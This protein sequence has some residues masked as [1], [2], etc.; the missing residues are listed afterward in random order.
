M[1]SETRRVAVTGLG[2]ISS[3]G[4]SYEQVTDALRSGASGIEAVPDWADFG[5]KSLVAGTITD[6]EE[7]I[8]ASGISRTSQRGM[9]QAALF[10]C[11]CAQ[12]AISGAGLEEREVQNIRTGVVV[13]TGTSSVS[14]V[15]KGGILA[16]AG[17]ANRID[18]F[19]ILRCMGSSASA[20]IAT[21]FKTQG[22]SYSPSA[23]CATSTHAIG[24]AFQL[25]R[26]GALDIAIAGGGED[27]DPLISSCFQG[28][29]TSMST[30]FNDTPE[31]ASRA[32]DTD[33][34]GFVISGGAGIVILED[35]QRAL[36]R[37]ATIHAE[38][39]GYGSTSDGHNMVAPR[40]DGARVADCMRLAVEDAGLKPDDIDYINTHGTS[41]PLGDVAELKGIRT[42]FGSDGPFISSTKSATGHAIGA[43]GVHEF[44]YCLSML[45]NGFIAPSINI[46]QL[47]PEGEDLAIVRKT[48]TRELGHVL[49]NNFGF[50]GTNA[51]LALKRT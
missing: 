6:F 13:G 34:D 39:M 45:E 26:S 28:Q 35:Y 30:G 41:T 36:D 1:S 48:L 33:R 44:I 11:L 46:E 38:V 29:R 25:V 23:A 50:G 12:D 21:H 32:F 31:K 40:P 18:P 43:A 9:S 3:I 20:A 49:T 10:S 22:L 4:N 16:Q 27:F 14:S 42:V 5:I 47:D 8:A 15:L 19:S 24:H 51:S 7:K 17:K 37:G 2:I